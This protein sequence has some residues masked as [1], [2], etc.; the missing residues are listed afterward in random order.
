MRRARWFVAAA[1]GLP[2]AVAVTIT[3]DWSVRASRQDRA[4]CQ[5]MRAL[6]LNTPAFWQAGTV[7]RVPQALP[8]AVDLRMSPLFDWD[9]DGR[10]H[11]S[12]HR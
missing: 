10:M 11:L 3:L 6:D 12:P 8:P 5:W 2:L 4:A 9:R 1:V 7:R